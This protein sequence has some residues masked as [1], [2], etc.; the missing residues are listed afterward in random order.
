MTKL[1]FSLRLSVR[2]L[3]M[4]PVLIF[5]NGCQKPGETPPGQASVSTPAPGQGGGWIEGIVQLDTPDRV[6]GH[7]GI[8]VYLAGT[9]PRRPART[10]MAN[11]SLVTFRTARSS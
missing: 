8:L 4:L 9:H 2:A 11:S 1:G 10:A 5:L 6:T 7:A 3:L